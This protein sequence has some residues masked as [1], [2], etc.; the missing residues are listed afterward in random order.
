MEIVGYAFRILSSQQNPYSVIWFVVQV[1]SSFFL[2]TVNVRTSHLADA[3]NPVL[4]HRRRAGVLLGGNLLPRVR[5][6]HH[7]RS[8]IRADAAETCPLDLRR[9][10]RRGD[11][12]PNCRRGSGGSSV[13]QPGGP[14][15]AEQHSLGGPRL[16]G[17]LICHLPGRVV[18]DSGESQKESGLDQ[19][20]LRR[21]A[22]CCDAGCVLAD[23]LSVGRDC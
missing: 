23:L 19:Q 18:L 20:K 10:R 7:L 6:D 9:M 13:F 21:C 16:P 3:N 1:R 4:L 22:H 12:R 8:R 15:D 17:V 5:H 14:D 2:G 11:N